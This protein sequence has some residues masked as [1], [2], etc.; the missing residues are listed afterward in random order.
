MVRWGFSLPPSSASPSRS[1]PGIFQENAPSLL[2]STKAVPGIQLPPCPQ[3]G[4]LTMASFKATSASVKR[5][6]SPATEKLQCI[7]PAI[8]RKRRRR[9]HRGEG[10]KEESILSQSHRNGK[11]RRPGGPA[12]WRGAGHWARLSQAITEQVSLSRGH[13]GTARLYSLS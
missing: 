4:S 13:P 11:P 6:T 12:S 1:P 5:D 10:T 7:K 2:L 9:M 3:L 8:R